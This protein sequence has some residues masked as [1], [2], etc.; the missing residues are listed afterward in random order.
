MSESQ[1]RQW[2]DEGLVHRPYRVRKHVV[3]FDAARLAED[4]DKIKLQA[5]SQD[6][7]SDQRGSDFGDNPWDAVLR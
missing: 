7:R 3:L 4:W 6:S 1:L 5:I 2:V